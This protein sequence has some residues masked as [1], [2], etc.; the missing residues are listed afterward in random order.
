MILDSITFDAEKHHYYNSNGDRY[1]SCTQIV[2]LF[3]PEFD[4]EFW[5]YYKALQRNLGYPNTEEGKV[6][7]KAYLKAHGWVFADWGI[8]N[9]NKLKRI[10]EY[11]GSSIEEEKTT[12]VIEQEWKTINKSRL[13]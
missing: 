6:G 4:K 3:I 2:E 7:Y 13:V 9:L 10:A 12:E 8:K 5:L 11:S 1:L